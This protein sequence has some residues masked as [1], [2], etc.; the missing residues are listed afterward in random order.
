MFRSLHHIFSIFVFIW[1][2][3]QT[4]IEFSNPTSS[5]QFAEQICT[6]IDEGH[7]CAPVELLIQGQ[8]RI[9]FRAQWIRFAR[10]PRGSSFLQAW[11]YGQH[12]RGSTCG[13]FL[14][15]MTNSYG[16]S[17][18]SYK[19]GSSVP[20]LSGGSYYTTASTENS[21]FVLPPPGVLWPDLIRYGGLE[22]TDRRRGDLFYREVGDPFGKFITGERIFSM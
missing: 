15:A 22:Y 18:W 11:R 8:Q 7:C 6:N 5:Y 4:Q 9:G 1:Q 17:E 16:K 12:V 21:T 2:T 14:A 19:E 10:I 20:S 3:L 13:D